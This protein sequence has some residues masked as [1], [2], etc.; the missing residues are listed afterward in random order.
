MMQPPLVFNRFEKPNV[1]QSRSHA[2]KH[3]NTC[4]AEQGLHTNTLLTDFLCETITN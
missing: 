4:L 2:L 3:N 1:T